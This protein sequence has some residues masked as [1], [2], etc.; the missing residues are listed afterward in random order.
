M[1]TNWKLLKDTLHSSIQNHAPSVVISSSA[2]ASWFTHSVKTKIN[3]NGDFVERPIEVAGFRHVRS[4]MIVRQIAVAKTKSYSNLL[5][6]R[7]LMNPRKPWKIVNP[8]LQLSMK[9]IDDG[10]NQNTS[11][12]M[13]SIL[14]LPVYLR[15]IHGITMRPL[16]VTTILPCL[17]LLFHL[18]ALRMLSKV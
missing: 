17:T 5:P 13:F 14:P 12:P 1:E 9:L 2:R 16:T 3:K 6:S 15:A 18:N 11:A 10:A 4:R 8:P 7:L